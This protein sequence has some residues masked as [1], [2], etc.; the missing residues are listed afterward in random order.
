M[1]P[2]SRSRVRGLGVAMGLIASVVGA[3][4]SADAKILRV[5]GPFGQSA[6]ADDVAVVV[7]QATPPALPAAAATPALKTADQPDPPSARAAEAAARAARALADESVEDVTV[8]ADVKSAQTPL[9]PTDVRKHGQPVAPADGRR[10]AA[11][12]KCVAGC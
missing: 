5:G 1:S 4:S 12:I 9:P 11:A 8:T 7:A 6:G 2:L 3:G 10:S